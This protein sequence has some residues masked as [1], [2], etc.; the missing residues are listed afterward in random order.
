MKAKPSGLNSLVHTDCK[1]RVH[2]QK[3]QKS[4]LFRTQRKSTNLVEAHV[5]HRTALACPARTMAKTK[6]VRQKIDRATLYE[7]DAENTP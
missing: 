4:I 5:N 7:T 3:P 1:I 2:P 6:L